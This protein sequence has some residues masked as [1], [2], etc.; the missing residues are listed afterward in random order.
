MK[1][2]KYTFQKFNVQED[3]ISTKGITLIALIVTIIVMIILVGV[4]LKLIIGDTGIVNTTQKTKIITEYTAAKEIIELK[5]MDI[6]ADCIIRKTEY[7]IIEVANS[8]KEY[9]QITIEKYYNLDVALIKNGINENLL[10]LKSILVKANRYPRYKFL[11]GEKGTIERVATQ[12]VTDTTTLEEDENQ[13]LEIIEDF[14]EKLGICE[15]TKEEQ[16]ENINIFRELENNNKTVNDLEEYGMT[17]NRIGKSETNYF[18][19][20]KLYKLGQGSRS[21]INNNTFT[22]T[23][24]YST[25]LSKLE[26]QQIKGIYTKYYHKAWTHSKSYT[27]WIYSKMII[28]YDDNTEKAIQTETLSA[29]NKDLEA[30]PSLVLMFENG[31]KVSKIQIIIHMYDSDCGDAGGYIKSIELVR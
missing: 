11:I 3:I 4:V 26:D 28:K 19:Y 20:N 14:E 30:E 29:C 15:K 23:I 1:S 21:G 27:S 25:L 24:D 12:D 6:Q 8:M 10:N 5:L 31:K 22:L 18:P 7:N 13:V 16:K 17:V 9:E 2:K